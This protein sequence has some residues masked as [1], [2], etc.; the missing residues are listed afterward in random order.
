[1]AKSQE[2]VV[3]SVSYVDQ[4]RRDIAVHIVAELLQA[5]SPQAICQK[6]GQNR[7]QID[8]YR[9]VNRVVLVVLVDVPPR[10]VGRT[11]HPGQSCRLPASHSARA[12]LTIRSERAE[13]EPKRR[14][15]KQNQ[16]D[17]ESDPKATDSS[18][19]FQLL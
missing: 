11:G 18:S 2:G 8:R 4:P 16:L 15:R 6:S 14:F 19:D 7:I 10:T 12:S 13:D 17:G 9:I 5:L 1:M 3:A